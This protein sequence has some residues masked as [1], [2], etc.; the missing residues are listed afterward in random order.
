[1]GGDAKVKE[2]AAAS[3]IAKVFRDKLLKTYS[4]LYPDLGL[5]NHK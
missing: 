4:E 2:I 3:I 1:V 5:E